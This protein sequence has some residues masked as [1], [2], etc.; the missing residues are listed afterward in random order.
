MQF[1]LINQLN[2]NI[3]NRVFFLKN[4]FLNFSHPDQNLTYKGEES[5]YTK[6]HK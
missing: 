3:H 2:L 4:L 6:V 5:P 1:Q